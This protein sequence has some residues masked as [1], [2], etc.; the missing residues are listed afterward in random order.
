MVK[1]LLI[2]PTA[3]D[4]RG[5][6]IR[7]RRLHLP[8]LTLPLLAALTPAHV[9]VRLV[10]E[11]VEPIPFEE[12]WDLV[13]LT[14]MGSGIVRAWQIADRFRAR[15]VKVVIGGIAASLL[16]TEWT[17]AHA[18]IVV[19]GEAEAVWPRMLDD[20]SRG[21]GQPVYRAGR[22]PDL[23]ALPLPRYDLMNRARMG[24][25]RPVQA[26]RGC[27]FQCRFCSVTAFFGGGYRKRPVRQVVENVRAAKKSGSRHIAF[28]DDNIAVDLDYCRELWKALIPEH[29]IWM[30]QCSL[31]IAE[32]PDLMRLAHESGCR[33]LSIGIESTAEESLRQIDKSWNRPDRYADAFAALR[34]HG[35]DVS[36]E[37]IIGLDGDDRSVFR[38]TRDFIMANRIAV[39]RVHIITPVPGTPL[40]DQLRREGRILSH[41]IADYTGGKSVFRPNAMSP[42]ELQEGY[43]D[44]YADLFSWRSIL[45]RIV[46][47]PARLG[48]YMRAVVWAANLKYKG[49][50]RRRISPGIL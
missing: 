3:L 2:A 50:I 8:C 39:P 37:M 11:T 14:G 48:P 12:Q 38:R 30:S 36:T 15:G 32:H 25:W 9:R 28:I 40:Y 43:W 5:R 13:G 45:R 24:F 22:P 19:V 6:P 33:M 26:T 41:D 1:I 42:E 16:P 47:N 21:G 35:I 10:Y 44:M 17:L 49:H 4:S 18:D 7:Q 20:V 31:H 29:I 23:D 27:P 34:A 46:P